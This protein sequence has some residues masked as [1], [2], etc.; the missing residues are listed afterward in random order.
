[1]KQNKGRRKQELQ[2]GK[3]ALKKKNEEKH[4]IHKK[5]RKHWKM[6][7]ND[8]KRNET[9]WCNGWPAADVR[10]IATI[11]Q[12]TINERWEKKR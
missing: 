6:Q 10:V 4:M 1:M 11:E 5:K 12:T 7:W 9:A 2:K 8:K 3:N